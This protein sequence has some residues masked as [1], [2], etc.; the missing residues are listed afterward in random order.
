MSSETPAAPPPPICCYCCCWSIAAAVCLSGDMSVLIFP[1]SLLWTLSSI[2]LAFPSVPLAPPASRISGVILRRSRCFKF[3]H[4]TMQNS[5]YPLRW[6]MGFPSRASS[7]SWV[8]SL[9]LPMWSN[10]SIL[11]FERKILYSLGQCWSPFTDSI[12][13]LLRFNSVSEIRPFKFSTAVIRLF[14]RLSTLSSERWLIFSILVILLE[15]RSNTS[16]LFR[17]YRFLILSM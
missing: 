6:K 15:W 16:S 13:F 9:R 7:Y 8:A 11:L 17:F 5:K 12:R 2:A 14:A 1:L 10:F 3:G 4:V